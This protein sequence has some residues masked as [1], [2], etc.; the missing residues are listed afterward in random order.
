MYRGTRAAHTALG[1]DNKKGFPKDQGIE[2]FT[3]ND[4]VSCLIYDTSIINMRHTYI[5]AYTHTRIAVVVV[6]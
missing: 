4:S 5:Y 1:S 2:V 3:L 6:E